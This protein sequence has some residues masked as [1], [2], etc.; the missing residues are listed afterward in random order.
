MPHVDHTSE[1]EIN[2]GP[3]HPATHGVLRVIL[4]LQ[5]E[6][7]VNVRP[8]IGYLHRGVEKLSEARA[9]RSVTPYTDRLDYCAAY[10]EN[11]S[12][13]GAVEKL[14][15]IE[16]P[17]RAQYMRVVLAELQRIASHLVWLGTH[18]MDIGALTIFL[19]AFREREKVL[20]LFEGYCGARLTYNA[21][22]IGGMPFEFP[23]DWIPACRAFLD[24]LPGRIEQ[25]ERM[26]TANRIWRKRTE[27]VGAIDAATAVANGMTG[28]TL[29]GSGVDYDIR[30]Y[31]PYECYADLHFDVPV[32][33][34][35]D[36]YDRYLI[37]MEEMR[38]SKRL[39]LEALEKMPDGPIM[40]KVP[41]RLRPAKGAEAYFMTES[42][43]GE[44]SVYLVSDGSDKPYRV[45]YRS[46][47]FNNLQGLPVLAKGH[48]VADVVA[49]IGTI[50]IVLGCVDR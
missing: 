47:S 6:T 13:I 36:T 32:G 5:G 30:K 24:E 48:M 37:R 44:M 7:I 19:Y 38:Q 14:A 46:P 20:D 2:M 11:H 50:D 27:G 17:P 1:L 15:G 26:L 35:G 18:A 28:P 12:F 21:I 8:V 40:A 10:S 25:Y 22:R 16:V 29:R 41:G 4:Q 3:Q 9:Y 34:R 39:V 45:R 42:P 23:D 43:R 31:K 49:L 33:S